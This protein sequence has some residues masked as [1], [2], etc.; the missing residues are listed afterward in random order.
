MSSTLAELEIKVVSLDNYTTFLT[1]DH[2][3]LAPHDCSFPL[4]RVEMTVQRNSVMLL[5]QCTNQVS[6]SDSGRRKSWGLPFPKQINR[7][8]HIA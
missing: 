3:R 8:D 4:H 1:P 7:L 2:Y 5:L 6:L